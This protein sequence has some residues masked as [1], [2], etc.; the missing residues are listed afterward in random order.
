MLN[1][2]VILAQQTTGTPS[3]P[4]TPAAGG[5]G[6]PPQWIGMVPM[7]LIFGV[8]IF[9]MMRSQKKQ[10]Q[11]RKEMLS[12]IKSGDKIVT[13]GGIKGTIE[14]VKDDVYLLKIADGVQ[15]EI[16][17]AA[18]GQILGKDNNE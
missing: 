16:V 7:F 12:S 14:K 18:V 1:N 3:A 5:E 4:G 17:H 11:K 13:N 8:M 15:I 6:A 9:F 10:A 2:I